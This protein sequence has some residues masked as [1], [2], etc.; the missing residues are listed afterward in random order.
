MTLLASFS[1]R[2]GPIALNEID[3]WV[4]TG[5]KTWLRCTCA[6]LGE[7]AEFA[8]RPAFGF[9]EESSRN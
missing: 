8:A 5:T 3:R 1:P 9:A 2:S 7:E 4:R 6:G